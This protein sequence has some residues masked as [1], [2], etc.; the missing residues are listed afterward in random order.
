MAGLLS[1]AT[2]IVRSKISSLL[3]R[4]ENP[5]ETLDYS[6]EQMQTQLQNVKRGVADVV[7]AKKRLELQTQKLEQ[8]VVK[9]ETQARQ[10]VGAGREDLA[11]QALEKKASAQQQLQGLDQQVQQLEAQQQ[12]L[13]E[14]QQTLE[15]RIESFR[16]QKEVLKAQYSAAEAQ[17]RI[18][19]A[20]TGIGQHMNDTGLAIQ[21]ARDKTEEL[22]ARASAI[23]ELTESGALEDF[24]AGDQ[25]Q[26]DRELAQ[27]SSSSQ[28]EDELAKIKAEV[29]SGQQPKE[30]SAGD[31]EPSPGAAGGQPAAQQSEEASDS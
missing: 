27:I 1:R 22:Q 4:A 16:S 7:T 20:A 12:Q 17:V 28:V 15:S 5:T 14:S 9:L 30:I 6:Y 13:I 11:R 19:E 23:D 31:G 24:T 26:L 25:T 3:N 21:R 2:L 10:A 29:G 8:N 18:G